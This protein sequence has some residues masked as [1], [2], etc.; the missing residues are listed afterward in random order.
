MIKGEPDFGRF[1]D[2]LLLRRAYRR[3]PVFDFHVAKEHKARWLGREVKTPADDVEF[4]RQAGYD[5]VQ[6]TVFVRAEE[7]DAAIGANQGLAASHGSELGVIRSLE[8]FR[9]R[10]WSWQSAGRGDLSGVRDRL[11][12]LRELA[13]VIPSRMKIVLHTADV[14]TLAW[15]MIGFGAF[16]LA[17]LEQPEYVGEVMQSLADAQLNAAR[18]A[19]EIAGDRLGAI[20]YS[21][22]IAYTEGLFLSPAF[23]REALFPVMRRFAE[24]GRSFGGAP[25][26]YHSDGRL[27]DVLDDLHGVGVRGL[28]PLEP[29]SMDPLRIKRDWPGR[30]CLMGNVDLDLMSRGTEEEVEAQVRERIERLNEGGGYM[31]GVSNTVP[32]YVRFENYRRMLETVYSYE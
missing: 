20:F 15:E 27:Y 10:D 3:P 17:S 6:C 16:C 13:R 7:L 8:H 25:M 11:E 12:W 32:Q 31:V 29:K 18:A 24:I 9:S 30:F 1:L 2:T 5:Y 22:D 19:A 14:Y 4:W 21:D 28:Q 23:Y 26:I